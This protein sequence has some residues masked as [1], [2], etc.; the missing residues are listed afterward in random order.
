MTHAELPN[1]S[2]PELEAM[3]RSAGALVGVSEDLRP[4]VLE[5]ARREYEGR[6]VMRKLRQMLTV[7][8]L[9]FLFVN[10]SVESSEA[11]L[12]AWNSHNHVAT[13][14][15]LW[16]RA[17]SLSQGDAADGSL[18]WGAVE[19]IRELKAIR[20]RLLPTSQK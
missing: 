5:N 8:V 1:R 9:T 12:A 16:Q 20:S 15:G 17:A 13:N 18:D 7:F 4:R 14:Q 11:P 19:A 3:V 2:W 6:L 10:A